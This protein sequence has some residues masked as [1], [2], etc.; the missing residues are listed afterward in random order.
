MLA[1][2]FSA[3][4]ITKNRTQL[5][6]FV[7]AKWISRFQ[8]YSLNSLQILKFCSA[9]KNAS[10]F[11]SWNHLA[12]G[13]RTLHWPNE[14]LNSSPHF[15]MHLRRKLFQSHEIRHIECRHGYEWMNSCHC[16][17]ILFSDFLTQLSLQIP[18]SGITS[19]M[20]WWKSV[21]TFS[22]RAFRTN[23]KIYRK[24]NHFSQLPGYRCRI[25]DIRC[26]SVCEIHEWTE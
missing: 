23:R 2:R 12:F 4:P 17:A 11:Y 10:N 5:N 9:A 1:L 18:K 15:D 3:A 6:H 20:W 13:T 7:H 19:C 25:F 14:K 26:H 22:T 8:W 21:A 24:F 16:N